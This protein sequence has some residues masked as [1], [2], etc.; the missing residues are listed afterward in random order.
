MDYKLFAIPMD[1]NTNVVSV[2]IFTKL[3]VEMK[4]WEKV[5]SLYV[6]TFKL[7][8]NKKSKKLESLMRL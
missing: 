2:D 7:Q 8:I 1:N 3:E 5:E 4:L 6:R